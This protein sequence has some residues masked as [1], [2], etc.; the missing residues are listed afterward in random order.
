MDNAFAKTPLQSAMAAARARRIERSIAVQAAPEPAGPAAVP[1]APGAAQ[2]S[3][4]P[5]QPLTP[6]ELSSIKHHVPINILGA[7]AEAAGIGPDRAE[8]LA[9]RLSGPLSQGKPVPDA[10][11]SLFPDGQLPGGFLDA[12]RE[13][14]TAIGAQYGSQ[15]EPPAAAPEGDDRGIVEQA[16]DPFGTT[17]EMLKGG[18]R[19]IVGAVSAGAT[20]LGYPET[21]AAAAKIAADPRLAAEVQSYK[22]VDGVGSGARY[23]AG[24]A[25]ESA[26]EMA[27]VLGAGAAGGA[28]GGPAGVIGAGVA[29]STFFN[30]GR[31]LQRQ[32]AENP[33]EDTS[34][35]R[36]ITAGLAQGGLDVIVPGRIL[37]AFG[38][39][40]LG[41]LAEKGLVRAAKDVGTDTVVEGVTEGVQQI[42]EMGQAN[43][44]LLRILVNPG[45][46]ET[47]KSDE[48][49]SEVIESVIG[50][51]AVDGAFSTGAAVLG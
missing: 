25:S 51:A 24:L 8:D 30:T 9:Q 10:I 20:S 14:A 23:I 17:K 7:V 26:P 36:A 39:R 21:A 49:V 28:V 33:G 13:R 15:G 12:V 44:D 16:L 43:P 32:A 11:A 45:E 1:A 27:A 3:T 18:A 29:T 22:D 35:A 38:T 42:I 19:G 46:G 4:Q 6:F 5:E 48:L 50:G 37:G 41:A 40:L 34:Y 31:N 47:E 2:V